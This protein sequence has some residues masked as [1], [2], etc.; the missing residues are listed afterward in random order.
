MLQHNETH[1]EQFPYQERKSVQNELASSADPAHRQSA[2]PRR[3]ASSESRSSLYGLSSEPLL[4][5]V[6]SVTT[7]SSLAVP[8]LLRSHP[9]QADGSDGGECFPPNKQTNC[10]INTIS[11]RTNLSLPIHLAGRS[12]G[13][14]AISRPTWTAGGSASHEQRSRQASH[15]DGVNAV[16]RLASVIH[17]DRS[18]RSGRLPSHRCGF[19]SIIP[20]PL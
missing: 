6:H 3:R 11:V 16:G 7:L 12:V 19:S 1:F 14:N 13:R 20:S 9:T 8:C 10:L 5:T 15:D 4:W 2:L 18:S 17:P